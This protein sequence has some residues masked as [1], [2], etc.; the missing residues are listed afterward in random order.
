MQNIFIHLYINFRDAPTKKH[1]KN[2][3]SS[4]ALSM[5]AAAAGGAVHMFTNFL[6]VNNNYYMC[7]IR[8][9]SWVF[10][11]SKMPTAEI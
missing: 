10:L 8:C 6:K 11:S 3:Y 2:V 5:F 9:Q 1:L 4:L 7:L